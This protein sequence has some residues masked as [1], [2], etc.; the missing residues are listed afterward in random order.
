MYENKSQWATAYLR[1]KFF[2]RIRITSQCEVVNAI[3]KSY[4]RKKGC[5]FEFMHNFEQALRSYRNN[6]L[7]VDFK[8]KFTKPVMTTHLSLIESH[9][10]KIYTA[11]IFKEVKDEIT[12]A[13]SLIVKGKFV[14]NGFKT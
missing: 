9:A 3:I 7:V 13:E 11:E 2:G 4:V 1:E 8:S 12:K 5:I 14:R 6:E 10:V